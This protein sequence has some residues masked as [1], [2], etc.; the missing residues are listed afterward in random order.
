SHG[1]RLKEHQPFDSIEA[2]IS[3]NADIDSGSQIVEVAEHRIMVKDSDNGKVI[4]E[5][6]QDLMDLLHH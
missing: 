3:Q 4:A 2:A 6:I 5:E 1:L